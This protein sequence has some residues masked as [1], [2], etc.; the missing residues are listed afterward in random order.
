MLKASNLFFS[1]VPVIL[2]LLLCV[3]IPY[4]NGV[5]NSEERLQQ[6]Y[7]EEERA[8]EY[9]KR[10]HKFPIEK[11]NPDTPGWTRIFD[12]RFAQVQAIES[13]QQKWD[14]WVR[15]VTCSR[16]ILLFCVLYV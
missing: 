1:L 9:I 7:T 13:S 8:A 5:V 16:A 11:Y 2:L 6:R 10:G 15:C 14:G 4:H 12:Q 3:I